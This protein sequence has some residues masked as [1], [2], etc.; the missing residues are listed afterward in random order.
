MQD[1]GPFSQ[2]DLPSVCELHKCP[3]SLLMPIVLLL[4]G[5]AFFDMPRPPNKHP[6]SCMA[7]CGMQ[8]Q[9]TELSPD[10]HVPQLPV[11]NTEDN[12]QC[13]QGLVVDLYK[14]AV[15]S[16]G[17]TSRTLHN[18]LVSLGIVPQES[19]ELSVYRAAKRLW[20]EAATKTKR[21]QGGKIGM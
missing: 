16:T 8:T 17:A 1:A 15:D 7:E 14:K 3:L 12:G 2:Q 10:E 5:Q 6:F 20:D 9:D 21:D 19:V 13:K 4:A 11:F 18:W